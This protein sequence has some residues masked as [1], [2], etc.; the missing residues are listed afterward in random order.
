MTIDKTQKNGKLILAVNGRLDVN[1]ST[2]LQEALIPGFDESNDIELDF[3]EL[4]YLSSAGI[5]VLVAGQ[6][7]AAA[8]GA[9]MTI[10][11][12]TADVMDVFEMTALVNVFN[13]Q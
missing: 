11:H 5:R 9:V 4:A 6:K 10:T 13:I 7:T 2:L 1:S 12:V 3:T 8:K